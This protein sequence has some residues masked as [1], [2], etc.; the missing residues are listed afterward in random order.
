MVEIQFTAVGPVFD[1]R[2]E[3]A[4]A[5]IHEQAL[6]ELADYA[7][8]RIVA[9]IGAVVTER[10]GIYERVITTNRAVDS[11]VITDSASILG[12]WLEG[13]SRR[14]R[15]T[16]FKGYHAFRRAAQH[17]VTSGDATDIV[18]KVIARHLG[19]LQ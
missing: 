12:P 18:E 4:I 13:V 14:N 1:G 6:D 8:N 11:R 19:Q 5:V 9:V 17:M 2:A 10:T 7:H 16:R 3:H 15:S